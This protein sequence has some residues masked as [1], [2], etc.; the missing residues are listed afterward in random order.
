MYTDIQVAMLVF[1]WTLIIM[2][3]GTMAF[4]YKH[5]VRDVGCYVLN[6]G[7]LAGAWLYVT[8]GILTITYGLRYCSIIF[9][10]ATVSVVVFIMVKYPRFR[11]SFFGF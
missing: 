10:G 11:Q 1:Y 2:A 6:L 4:L 7:N 5:G 3:F 9:A 8:I